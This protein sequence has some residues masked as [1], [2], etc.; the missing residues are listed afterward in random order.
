MRDEKYIEA[1]EKIITHDDIARIDKILTNLNGGKFDQN[2]KKL[3]QEISNLNQKN[4]AIQERN[5]DIHQEEIMDL[6]ERIYHLTINYFEYTQRHNRKD[7]HTEKFTEILNYYFKPIISPHLQRILATAQKFDNNLHHKKTNPSPY[8]IELLHAEIESL[9]VKWEGFRKYGNCP[10]KVFFCAKYISDLILKLDKYTRT[11]RTITLR[12]EKALDLELKKFRTLLALYEK[13]SQNLDPQNLE[14][15][16]SLE[17]KVNAAMRFFI[18]NSKR[19]KKDKDKKERAI[20]RICWTSPKSGEKKYDDQ[21]SAKHLETCT[22]EAQYYLQK[23]DLA[24]EEHTLAKEILKRLIKEYAF[25]RTHNPEKTNDLAKT[26]IISLQ[27]LIHGENPRHEIDIMLE[28]LSR[29]PLSNNSKIKQITR[30]LTEQF[31][32]YPSKHKIFQESLHTL[33]LL[34]KAINVLKIADTLKGVHFRDLH[35]G[36]SKSESALRRLLATDDSVQDAEEAT[37]LIKQR[38]AE[39]FCQSLSSNQTPWLTSL[40]TNIQQLQKDT[41]QALDKFADHLD[42]FFEQFDNPKYTNLHA[43]IVKSKT[44]LVR[45]LL[46]PDITESMV[47]QIEDEMTK[48][49]S[50]VT[51]SSIEASNPQSS[52]HGSLFTHHQRNKFLPLST[53]YDER[54]FN[55]HNDDTGARVSW[56]PMLIQGKTEAKSSEILQS[57]LKKPGDHRPPTHEDAAA[58][59]EPTPPAAAQL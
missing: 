46:Q 28:A 27:M 48:L 15:L 13:A 20:P 37:Q 52:R 4:H 21:T 33:E 2:I 54:P 34:Y 49:T 26:T 7:P 58:V 25:W 42:N 38:E 31:R 29:S 11:F 8:Q 50:Y 40:E 22:E 43:E 36:I 47:R 18:G 9:I 10:S 32:L 6:E 35:K 19:T 24:E 56:S 17:N 41:T 39:E 55:P 1:Q 30:T 3:K 45:L 14:E 57:C 59:A 44:K 23:G 16:K 5:T 12:K 51:A 53:P